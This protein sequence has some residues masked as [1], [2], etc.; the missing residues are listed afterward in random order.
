MTKA[1]SILLLLMM[2]DMAG[3]EAYSMGSEKGMGE[4]R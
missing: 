1:V 4:R 3:R 2:M